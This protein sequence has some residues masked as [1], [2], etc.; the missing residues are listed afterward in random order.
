VVPDVVQGEARAEA[1]P[2]K[3]HPMKFILMIHGNEASEGRRTEPEMKQIV[4][5]H[6]KVAQELRAAK[7]VHGERLRSQAEATRL[8]SKGGQIQLTDGPFAETKEV[9]G[10]F[11]LI[12]CASKAEAV[13]W[14]SKLPL[15]E[16]GYIEVRP[17]WE[18]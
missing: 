16:E 18:M 3:E 5:Q 13:E 7:M 14:A 4:G 11:Y 2:G 9:V 10:G 12:D 15:R 6:M 1:P 17:I 8:R